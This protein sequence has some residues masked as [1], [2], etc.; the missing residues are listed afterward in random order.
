M[1]TSTNFGGVIPLAPALVMPALVMP[2]LVIVGAANA[3]SAR[4][5][6]SEKV[7]DRIGS[8]RMAGLIKLLVV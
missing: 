2:A 8:K 5:M 6:P 4:H 3:L 1:T 7:M